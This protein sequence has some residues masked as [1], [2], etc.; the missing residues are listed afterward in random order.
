MS[1]TGR[2]PLG[3]ALWRLCVT[4]IVAWLILYDHDY[5]AASC[6]LLGNIWWEVSAM[7]DAST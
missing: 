5:G 4:V 1:E 6:V 7:R 2:I 3:R